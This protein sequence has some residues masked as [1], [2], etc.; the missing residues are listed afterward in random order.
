RKIPASTATAKVAPAIS[1]VKLTECGCRLRFI[2]IS[3]FRERSQAA[4]GCGARR[5]PPA[6]GLLCRSDVFFESL[7]FTHRFGNARFNDIADRNDA[8]HLIAVDHRHMAKTAARHGL[9]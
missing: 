4:D 2:T 5:Q 7:G 8:G 9:H 1:S 6:Y 3:P